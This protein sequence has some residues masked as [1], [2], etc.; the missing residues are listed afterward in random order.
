[1]LD[2]TLMSHNGEQFTLSKIAEPIVLFF[3]PRD[4]TPG[5]TIENQDFARLSPEFKKAGYEVIGISRDSIKSHCKFAEK[6]SLPFKLLSDEDETVCSLFDVMKEKNMY[7]KK[8]R[9][10]ER[11]TFIIDTHQNIIKEWRKVTVPNHAQEV[12]EFVKNT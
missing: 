11:S 7:G 4:D 1:M 8:V 12:L 10:I 9:G 2:F 3:Y 5:C 6:F